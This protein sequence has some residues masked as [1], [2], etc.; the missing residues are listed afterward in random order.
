MPLVRRILQCTLAL[1]I[2]A[3]ALAQAPATTPL[4]V[5]T[6]FTPNVTDSVQ[7]SPSG[8]WMAIQGRVQGERATLKVI[9]LEGKQPPGIVAKFSRFD[10]SDFSWVNDDWLVFSLDDENDKSG[11]TSYG[12]LNAVRRDGEKMRALIKRQFD[13]AFQE[14]GNVALEPNNDM[15]AVGA[16]GSNEIVIGENHLSA[17]YSEYVY[18]SLRTMDVS[19]GATRVFFKTQPEPPVR[20]VS[21]LLDRK[22]VA[23]VGVARQDNTYS[24]WWFDTKG[25]RWRKIAEHAWGE[26]DFSP[27]YV[28][29]QDRLFV[30]VLNHQTSLS[31]LREFDFASGKPSSAVVISLPGFD[32]DA[33]PIGDA[34]SNKVHGVRLLTDANSVAWFSPTMRAIQEKADALLPGR[35]N[36]ITCHPCEAPKTVLVTS[37]SDT[38]PGEFLLYRPASGQFER[39]A[40]VRPGHPD[41][42]MANLELYR[43]TT[44]DGADL[45]VW[46]T[47]TDNGAKGPRPAVVL[48]H[49]GPWVRG[50]SWEWDPQVQ[51]LASRGYV[52][53]EPEFR[54][55]TGFGDRHFRAGWKQ[56]GQ[57][58][59]DDVSDALRFAVGKG[60][61]DAKRV[62]IAGA[63]YGGY[64]ALMGPIRDPGQYQC[65]VAWVG[66]SDPRLL[67]SVFWS[68]ISDVSKAYSMPQ[69]IGDP[70]K[71]AAMLSAH[72]P[73]E[74][75][76]R[77][78]VP[79][80]LAYGARDR[81][82][83]LAHGERMRAALT[84]A[85][86]PPEWIVYDDE[87]HGWRR[88]TNQLDFWRRVEQFLA[89]H[90]R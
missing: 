30:T 66:V 52:V 84:A 8:R 77:I 76:A 27:A 68:D 14:Q 55:S 11:R 24:V 13:S 88:T 28:D 50:T 10:V 33:A 69:M 71:D 19:T 16:P 67:Y 31:E 25:T 79:V 86:N 39:I 18:Q 48:V 62:C 89:K 87:G 45:P 37:Y 17:D 53:I 9:D 34:G 12:G 78:K 60:W 83:P 73:L 90:L 29:E 5:E 64:A 70:Q 58:M 59:Q 22:G 2:S 63:S 1:V 75:A 46:I 38:S 23:R 49:G 47:Q 65:S 51:F 4:P 6:F 40:S 41:K 57:R 74:Q 21:W 56:W 15:L 61:V 42:Q 32:A 72:A 36:H 44:R 54:G 26:S 20:M 85:G 82:V 3:G 80:L 43:T 81:R 35:V 7:V